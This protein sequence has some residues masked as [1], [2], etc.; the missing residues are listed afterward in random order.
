MKNLEILKNALTNI[1]EFSEADINEENFRRTIGELKA[2][3]HKLRARITNEEQLIQVD[4]IIGFNIVS[5]KHP[6]EQFFIRHLAPNK[7][8]SL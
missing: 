1:Q 6:V 8:G 4:D 3:L 5:Q 2:T 7:Y